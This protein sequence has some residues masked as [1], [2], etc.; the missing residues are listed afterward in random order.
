MI[1]NIEE[2]LKQKTALTFQIRQ[3][4]II[5]I[6]HHNKIIND[7]RM[8]AMLKNIK[9]YSNKYHK[10]YHC[11]INNKWYNN[12]Y[13]YDVLQDIFDTT[14]LPIKS[15]EYKDLFP[16]VQLFTNKGWN[17]GIEYV[18]SSIIYSYF[19]TIIDIHNFKGDKDT[20]DVLKAFNVPVPSKIETVDYS[21]HYCCKQCDG[22]KQKYINV[23]KEKYISSLLKQIKMYYYKEIRNLWKRKKRLSYEL[24]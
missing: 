21:A 7:E 14:E 16:Y 20:N 1:I 24:L 10:N 2:L 13:K 6:L 4:L 5:S 8:K 19:N 23:R 15:L 9:K 3:F 18:L 17:K 22:D 11:R 12:S